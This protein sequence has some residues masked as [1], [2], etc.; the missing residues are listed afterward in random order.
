MPPSKLGGIAGADPGFFNW[1]G[2]ALAT[3]GGLGVC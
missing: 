1:G 3:G 2:G